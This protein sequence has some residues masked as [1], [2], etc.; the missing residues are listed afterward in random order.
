[1]KILLVRPISDTYII[2]PPIGLGYLATALR[3]AK[4]QPQILDCARRGFNFKNFENFLKEEKPDAV[5]F[6]VWS[7]DVPNVKKSLDI[8]KSVNPT[9][10][11]VVGGAHPSGVGEKA[12]RDFE[13]ADFAFR[14]EG[15]IGL[16]LLAEK[17]AHNKNIAL[18]QIPGLIWREGESIRANQPVF[19]E[20]LDSFELPAWDLIDPRTYP[21][22]PH[23]GFMKAHPAAPI[24]TTRGCPYP[25]TFCATRTISGI[26]IRR[27]GIDSI[28]EEIK[29]LNRKYRVKEI[30][31]EDDNFTMDK[32]FVKQFCRKLLEENLN[33]FWYCSSGLRVDCLNEEILLLMKKSRCYT[34]TVAIESGSQRIL[35]LMKKNLT[36]DTIKDSVSLMNKVGYKPTGLFMLGFPDETKE[37]M[38]ETL[39]FAMSLNLKRAQFAIFHPMPGSEI[40]DELKARGALKNIDWT[41]IKPSEI[42]C[43]PEG[44]SAKELKRFQRKAFLKFHARPRI[45]YYQLKEIQS[46]GHLLFLL[47]RV[48]AM[49]FSRG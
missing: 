7:C 9:V 47:K 23:Q 35:N 42:A 14:G 43:E 30:H 37:E 29:L 16:P 11:T 1:M 17:L 15:E 5:G 34:L 40:F 49:L 38:N 3:K 24:V 26:K 46:F 36:L 28:I 4:H 10:I 2:T 13:K 18:E 41:K 45:L 27:R 19:V 22:A 20:D 32:N 48:I 21:E 33:I 44:I 12:L 25:C 31:V 39:K 6:Q 8:A